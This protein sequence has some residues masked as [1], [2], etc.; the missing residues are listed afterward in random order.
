MDDDDDNAHSDAGS[1]APIEEL[2][3]PDP[4]DATAAFET[5]HLTP[6]VE[7]SHPPLRPHP[8]SHPQTHLDPHANPEARATPQMNPTTPTVPSPPSDLAHTPVYEALMLPA[9][10]Q[11]ASQIADLIARAGI[12]SPL[13]RYLMPG[14][15]SAAATSEVGLEQTKWLVDWL[16]ATL[17][18]YQTP[19][20][21]L[22]HIMR[23]TPDADKVQSRAQRV[24]AVAIVLPN[25]LLLDA[26][27]SV[28]T[29]ALWRQPVRS[30][31]SLPLSFRWG[32]TRAV[33]LYTVWDQMEERWRSRAARLAAEE[34]MQGPDLDR[35]REAKL[36]TQTSQEHMNQNEIGDVPLEMQ[37]IYKGVYI[38]IICAEPALTRKGLM[39]RLLDAIGEQVATR[40][41]GVAHAWLEIQ[42]ERLARE[43]QTKMGARL[44]DSF[45]YKE[46]LDSGPVSFLLQVTKCSA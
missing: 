33:R 5:I 12:H 29:K 36:H 18:D 11:D 30:R 1:E 45:Q 16:L 35:P 3:S 9:T 32:P 31:H 25:P 6:G 19:G 28:V 4:K 15:S 17:R 23:T 21:P 20:Q 41:G 38:P 46:E 40:E 14:S 27:A 43:M 2:A 39:T 22:V 37:D 24:C 26:G 10:P 8:T 13:L 7:A 34:A 42:D 44:V